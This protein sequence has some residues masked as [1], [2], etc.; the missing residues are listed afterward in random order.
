MGVFREID[1]NDTI[2]DPISNPGFYTT[3]S[4]FIRCVND[5]EM[6]DNQ[7]LSQNKIEKTKLDVHS[8]FFPEL[9][10][11][12][13]S[14]ESGPPPPPILSPARR[15][16]DTYKKNTTKNLLTRK[17]GQGLSSLQGRLPNLPDEERLRL[18]IQLQMRQREQER[19]RELAETKGNVEP[20][21]NFEEVYPDREDGKF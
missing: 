1:Y 20:R 12:P 19:E 11:S 17:V 3:D 2:L 9:P 6:K 21:V 14:P 5:F 8:M 18:A 10:E 15:Q 16:R 4:L 13:E 7:V